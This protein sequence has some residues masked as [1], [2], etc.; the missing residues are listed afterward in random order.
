[1][2]TKNHGGFFY[3]CLLDEISDALKS[4]E[5]ERRAFLICG[6][7][8]ICLAAVGPGLNEEQSHLVANL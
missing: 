6:M 7:N 5:S 4:D 1:M 3:A 8:K 2:R